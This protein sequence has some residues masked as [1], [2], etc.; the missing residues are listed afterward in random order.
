MALCAETASLP[1]RERGLKFSYMVS[2]YSYISSLPTRE[3][4][5]KLCLIILFLLGVQS[6]PT[7]E[8]GLKSKTT[9]F[10]KTARPVA[11]YAGAWIEI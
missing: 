8:R 11:P 10:D 2:C 5:L 7:R 1:T 6:L 9:I 3:R 4:G